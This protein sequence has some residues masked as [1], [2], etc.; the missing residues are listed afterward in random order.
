MEKFNDNELLRDPFLEK[1]FHKIPFESTS[2]NFTKQ[3]MDQLSTNTEPILE[4]DKYRRQMLWAYSS[5]GVGI[6]VIALMLFALWPFVEINFS[7]SSTQILNFINTSLTVIK[8]I[9]N[10]FS[11]LK[12]STVQISIFFSLML[13][14]LF[15]RL[16]RKGV[17]NNNSYLL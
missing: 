9:A 6:L 1:M 2:V 11:Y 7:L 8:S 10:F 14:F 17:S 13:L 12:G 15:E 3:V 4:P 5:I 16:L